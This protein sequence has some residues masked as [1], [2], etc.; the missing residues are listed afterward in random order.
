MSAPQGVRTAPDEGRSHPA[1]ADSDES[2]A[3][4]AY[5]PAVGRASG[6]RAEY[7]T[8]RA[9]AK[10][11]AGGGPAEEWTWPRGRGT[12]DCSRSRRHGLPC[13]YVTT[14]LNSSLDAGN[15]NYP[16]FPTIRREP[17]HV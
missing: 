15:L 3:W 11:G 13:E 17:T 8:E 6:S 5:A 1:R 2:D 14:I 12:Q 4:R 7:D 9:Q 10:G 16:A